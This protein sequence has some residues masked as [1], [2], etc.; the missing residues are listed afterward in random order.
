MDISEVRSTSTEHVFD[1]LPAFVDKIQSERRSDLGYRA[2]KR[3]IDFSIAL[4]LLAISMPVM[5]ILAISIRLTSGGPV[6]F[7]QER[8]GENGKPF[9]FY[10]FRTMA[11]NADNSHHK[12][13]MHR[14]IRGEDV[15]DLTSS[16]DEGKK[17][18]KM[19]RDP[20]ITALGYFLR[21]TSLDE[22]PQ[23]FNVLNGTMSLVGPR[24]P[25]PYEVDAYK[26]WHMQRLQ[27]RPGIT[28][29]WQVNGRSA[30]TFDEMVEMDL[31]YIRNRSIWYDFKLMFQ[32]IP[33]TLNTKTAA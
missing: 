13:F 29:A 17:V 8:V 28:G 11:H 27:V 25:I 10:K 5:A 26:S 20:R 18:Y 9:T 22:L 4:I 15:S 31:A 32:T 3:V 19:Q 30:T 16:N 12:E 6:L 7:R 23:F 24:P 1:P 2:I 33:A 14:F 21:K